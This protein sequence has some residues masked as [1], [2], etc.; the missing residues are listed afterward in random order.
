MSAGTPR[1]AAATHG[2][3][4]KAKSRT[5]LP[6]LVVGA[7]GV[8]FGDIGTSP[9]Y[10]LREAFS[11]HY[12]LVANHDTVLGI[13]SLVF[14]ALTV[15]VTLKYVTIIMRADNEG[16][17]G[18]MALMALAQRSLKP[19]SKS[20][21]M[22]GLLGVFGASLFFG[23]GV[24][25]P[26]ISV[27]SAVEGLEV[28]APGLRRWIVPVTVLV[29]AG[30]FATQRYGT[31]KVGRVFGPITILWFLSLAVLGVVNILHEP[32]VLQAI[33]P[34]WGAKFFME[35]SWGGVFILGAVVLAVTGGEAIY[36]DMG[37]FGPRPIRL[38]WYWFVLPALMLNYLGQGALVL[39]DPTA[40]RN[41]FYI[42]VPEWGRWPMIVLATA[43]TVIASQ[44]VITGGFSVARQAMQLGYIPRM[45]IK[46][47]SSETIGQIYIPAINWSMAIVVIGLVLAF[48]SSS[49]LAVA[50]GVSVSMTMLIDTLLLV[51]VARALWLRAR[52]W[53]LP[54]CVAFVAIEVAFVVANGAKILQGGWF[55][56]VLG[57][58]LF[59]ML[60][61]WRHGRELLRLAVQ[62]EGIRLDTFI[63]GLMLAPPVRVPGTAIF[64][65]SDPGVVPHALMH[66]LKHNKV[67]H[68]RNVFLTAETLKV[69]YAPR[70]RRLEV[71]EIGD[72]FY[73][74]T[75]RFGFME[76]PDLPLALMRSCDVEGM[77]F[78]PMDTTYF[79]S[80]ETIVASR[81]VGMPV[82]RDKLFAFMH[83][84]AAPANNFFR[85]PGNRLV[86]LGAQVEI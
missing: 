56:L 65:T 48:G 29:L 44:A 61:T 21:Y 81:H 72:D 20:V 66:N 51:I 3:P 15:V 69:P 24:I 8:V 68:E 11:P 7:V 59:T 50:Y 74:V 17:G 37:H 19:G 12:G 9:L 33:N 31:E 38:G 2:A 42:G 45:R 6:A 13:L 35:H 22:V 76:T 49:R 70:E 82:W 18:I 75:A 34:W 86:E 47:T 62:K 53:V 4:G 26:A 30:L 40:I 79:V 39:E 36:T 46:H 43:A 85:I 23:D 54:C 32:E 52:R 5:G 80:R 63:P 67:L 77:D 84:N 16:E 14:W 83:R 73:R 60:R 78:D 57:I 55:P 25:T 10:T 27:L 58:V 1:R 64:L 41:P 71:K 28:V